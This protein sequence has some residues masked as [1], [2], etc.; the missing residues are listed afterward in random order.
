MKHSIGTRVQVTQLMDETADASYFNKIGEV[1][2][3]ND[4]MKTGNT[5]TSPLHCIAFDD[6]TTEEYWY[7]ELT[8]CK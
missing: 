1:Y 4:N 6:G 7:E 3:Y 8:P 2:S 5:T